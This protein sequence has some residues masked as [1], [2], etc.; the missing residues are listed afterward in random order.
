MKADVMYI[1][2]ASICQWCQLLNTLPGRVEFA[3]L[4]SPRNEHA[5]YELQ[6]EPDRTPKIYMAAVS[7][8][9]TR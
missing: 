7:T 2:I 8:K 6:I 1:I 9:I 5:I 4:V 3:N